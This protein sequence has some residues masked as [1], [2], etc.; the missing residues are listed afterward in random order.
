MSRSGP[1]GSSGLR[2]PASAALGGGRG[3]S[4]AGLSRAAER[5]SAAPANDRKSLLS[6]GRYRLVCRNVNCGEGMIAAKADAQS[7][8]TSIDDDIGR[9]EAALVL[10]RTRV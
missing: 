1:T 10:F 8:S 2:N 3:V 5:L 9:Q 7:I 6:Q 4:Q